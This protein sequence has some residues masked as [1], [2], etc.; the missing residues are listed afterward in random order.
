MEK[1]KLISVKDF[2]PEELRKWQLKLLEILVYFR[3]FCEEHNLRFM[4]AGGTC[5]GTVRHKGFIPWDDDVDVQ[6]P[7]DDYEKLIRI[8]N[9]EA[10]TSKFVCDVTT[11]NYCSKFPM[12]VI[13]SV[14]TTCIYD[15]SIDSDICQGL[16]IDVEFLDGVPNGKI[17]RKINLF[18]AYILALFR[19]QRI[20]ARASKIKTIGS[21]I[22]L[23]LFPSNS[24]KWTISRICE[25]RIMKYKFDDHDVVRYLFCSLQEKSAF[26]EIVYSEFEG[27]KMPI[28][29]GYDSY[30][31]SAYHDY[32]QLPPENKRK[33]AT[34]N[35]FFYDLD[36]SYLDYKGKY[37]CVKGK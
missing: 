33:P 35:L 28:P 15:H 19:S 1:K 37:Y 32:M 36:H 17:S 24:L 13:R 20:P 7:R 12:A 10:D 21:S 14:G 16:K 18:C 8:W 27:Y 29:V 22:L 23:G 25:K 9:Q 2:T 30:L 5:L 3:D 4:L 34:D 11:K 6:M 26:E 31:R